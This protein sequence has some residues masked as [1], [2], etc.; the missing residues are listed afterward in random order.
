[1]P[2]G[3]RFSSVENGLNAGAADV[4]KSMFIDFFL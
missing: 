2:K 4:E 1:M 3:G